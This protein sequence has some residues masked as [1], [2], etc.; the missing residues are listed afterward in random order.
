MQSYL[1]ILNWPMTDW[2]LISKLI[3]I[4]ASFG[5]NQSYAQTDSIKVYVNDS[6]VFW[7]RIVW[8]E[9]DT[10]NGKRIAVFEK[11]K[12]VEAIVQ[13]YKDGKPNGA[14]KKYYPS[15]QLMEKITYSAGI[16]N[17]EYVLMSFMGVVLIKGTYKNNL[18]HG[19]WENKTLNF[20]GKY[21]EGKRHGIWKWTSDGFNYYLYQFENGELKGTYTVYPP[22]Y[23]L[24]N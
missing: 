19:H 8:V 3:I 10:T 7:H 5:I 9:H 17:G 18:K 4:L 24:R 16:K 2:K 12:S 14:W 6:T 23:L 15:G 20:S 11:N 1:R 13:S 21:K 22:E